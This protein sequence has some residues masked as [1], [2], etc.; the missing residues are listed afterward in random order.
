MGFSSELEILQ[1]YFSGTTLR[2]RIENVGLI[3]FDIDTIPRNDGRPP[4]LG[5]L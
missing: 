2:V 1:D 3:L 5:D 4:V